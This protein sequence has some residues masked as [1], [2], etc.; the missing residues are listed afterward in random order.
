M[1]QNNDGPGK[2]LKREQ[3]KNV[4]FGFMRPPQKAIGE[5]S[6]TFVYQP[7]PEVAESRIYLQNRPYDLKNQIVADV[8]NAQNL[9]VQ[10]MSPQ[11][12]Q[13]VAK[14]LE[15]LNKK[16]GNP[17][18]I[19]YEGKGARPYYDSFF[20][21]MNI[22]PGI[23][24][25]KNKPDIYFQEL[26]HSSQS[27]KEPIKS[28]IKSTKGRLLYEDSSIPNKGRYGTPGEFEYEAHKKIAPQLW[29]EFKS[30]YKNRYG[31]DVPPQYENSYKDEQ[32]K[33]ND[34]FNFFSTNKAY[35]GTML[36]EV[37]IVSPVKRP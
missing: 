26:A 21:E 28:Y 5:P 11:Q 30:L 19:K 17:L 10:N 14:I 37:T 27:E 22:S 12:Y 18:V 3:A 1:A 4:N 24:Q 20:N 35:K 23:R 15:E 6:T 2:R 34:S 36:P 29:N 25:Y 31:E 33:L 16:H 8:A 32:E 13:R 7:T 9:D